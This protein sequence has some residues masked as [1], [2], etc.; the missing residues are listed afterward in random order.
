MSVRWKLSLGVCSDE[1][2]VVHLYTS[3]IHWEGDPDVNE[4]WT[5]QRVLE[6]MEDCAW[7]VSVRVK[8]HTRK[9]ITGHGNS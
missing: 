6:D 2:A 3:T 4:L 5:G 9:G 1:P 8:T 7:W